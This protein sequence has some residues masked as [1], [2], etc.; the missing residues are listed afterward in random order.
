MDIFSG[1]ARHDDCSSEVQRQRYHQGACY[2]QVTDQ[3]DLNPQR[4]L[5]QP[6]GASN[7]S[8]RPR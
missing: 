7:F 4:E 5:I 6:Q 1:P 3:K 2:L 8:P